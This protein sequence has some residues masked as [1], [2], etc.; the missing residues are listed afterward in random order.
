MCNTVIQSFATHN[1]E[2]TKHHQISPSNLCIQK[3]CKSVMRKKKDETNESRRQKKN[4]FNNLLI[5]KKIVH[6]TSH[7]H[8][9]NLHTVRGLVSNSIYIYEY[10]YIYVQYIFQ[11]NFI[12]KY[13]HNRRFRGTESNL[14]YFL[15]ER[16]EFTRFRHVDF[17]SFV[18]IRKS[19]LFKS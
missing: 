6:L 10:I 12:F 17:F 8:W 13:M 16:R 11:L 14:I 15:L 5:I 2:E 4:D 1:F 9:N 19:V 3:M 7:W 18:N